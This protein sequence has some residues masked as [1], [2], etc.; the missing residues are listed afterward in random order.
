MTE[1]E[2]RWLKGVGPVI[3]FARDDKL[4][5]DVI[6]QPQPNPGAAPLAMAFIDGR[7]KL[8]LSMRG[9]PEAKA[10][11][12]RI[13]P[14]LLDATLELMAAHELGHCRR[15]LDGA[16]YVV[17]SGFDGS[18]YA[19]LPPGLRAAAL[20]MKA[21]RREEG[22]GDLVGLAWIRQRHPA[23]YPTLHAW[24]LAERLRGRIPGS[25]HDTVAWLRVA[26]DGAPLAHASIFVAASALWN[27]V[28][29]ARRGG[30]GEIAD[31]SGVD[32]RVLKS[33]R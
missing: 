18:A 15:Y 23:L 33:T 22:F 30:V 16:W 25:H 24:L 29:I 1:V 11:L 17:P 32:T 27:S 21:A 28:I 19:A 26:E 13:A 4:P 14:A 6:V 20:D 9:N 5:L 8:V 7:C 2:T 3:A 31:N 10:T 12:D